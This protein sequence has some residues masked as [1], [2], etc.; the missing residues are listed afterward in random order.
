MNL[1]SKI[2]WAAF[3]VALSSFNVSTAAATTQATSTLSATV[4]ETSSNSSV[5]DRLSR[6]SS[7]LKSK[8]SQLPETEKSLIPDNEVALGW[9]NGG[10]GRGFANVRRG[11]WGN[12]FGGG[13]ANVNPW[14]NGWGDG[15][16]FL[17]RG[18]PNGG[19][20]NRY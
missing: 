8:A 9:A 3:M 10:G 1:S 17:N 18:W 15:G 5:G 14:R 7:A 19:F 2:G 20:F 4:Q 12:G 11:G 13:F 16:G 6:I